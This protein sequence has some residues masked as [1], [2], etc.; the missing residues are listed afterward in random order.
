MFY[1]MKP[2]RVLNPDRFAC[3]ERTV[4]RMINHLREEGH[5]IYAG[6]KG[7]LM[8]KLLIEFE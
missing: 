4:R 2:V 3:S 8:L 7:V 5:Q 1:K 6:E